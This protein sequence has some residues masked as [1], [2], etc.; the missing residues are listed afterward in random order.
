MSVGVEPPSIK[1]SRD[2]ITP[3]WA[4]MEN[5]LRVDGCEGEKQW[6]GAGKRIDRQSAMMKRLLSLLLLSDPARPLAS[7]S[8]PT[9]FHCGALPADQPDTYHTHSRFATFTFFVFFSQGF[10]VSSN[11]TYP[12]TLSHE[13]LKQR[14]IS[15]EGNGWERGLNWVGGGGECNLW[16]FWSSADLW[17]A[18][19]HICCWTLMAPRLAAVYLTSLLTAVF[20]MPVSV[21]VIHSLGVDEEYRY[22]RYLSTANHCYKL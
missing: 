15:S 22:L 8:S 1:T 18:P 17:V 21:R 12:F 13:E 4:G 5:Q 6:I 9:A 7:P 14:W 19:V 3:W 11:S 16:F 2:S 10:T 20:D